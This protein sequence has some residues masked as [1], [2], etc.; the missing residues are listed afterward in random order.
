MVNRPLS[1]RVKRYQVSEKKE[2]IF[3]EAAEKYLEGRQKGPKLTYRAIEEMFPGVTKSKLQRY[4]TGKGRTRAE[5]SETQQKITPN[6]EIVL[7]NFIL[8]SADRGF[9]LQHREICQFANTILQSHLGSAYE[10]VSKSWIFRFLDRHHNKLQSHWSKPLDT[11]RARSLNPDAVK[12]WFDLVE[13]NIVRAGIAKENIY[14]M[15]ESG[16]PMAYTGKERVVGARGTK[17]QHKQ[18]GADRENVTALVTICADGS[19]PKPLIIFKG[20]NMMA[21]WNEGNRIN[22]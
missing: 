11:Q 1:E 15:D 12:S 22:A 16:F 6:E 9:P 18:G 7:I 13:E 8:E 3:H 5:Y 2:G 4:I 17:I 10:P 14:G 21:K 20:K 19:T